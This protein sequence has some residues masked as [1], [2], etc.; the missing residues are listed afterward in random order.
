[1]HYHMIKAES[2][3]ALNNKV[4]VR[5]IDTTKGIVEE[6]DIEHGEAFEIIPG[7]P[8]QLEACYG[9]VDII[10]ASTYHSDSDIY[11]VWR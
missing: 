10:E 2:F 11:R 7:L 9:D 4:K 5:V 6:G 8:H 1:M 3:Y